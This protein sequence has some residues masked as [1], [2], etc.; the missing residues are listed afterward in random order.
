MGDKA[1]QEKEKKDQQLHIRIT[2]SQR[3]FLDMLSYENDKSRT[4]MVWRA[5][6][7]YHNY[8]KGTFN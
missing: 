8:H 7:F 4:D 1:S 2:K 3:D 6:E 5:L